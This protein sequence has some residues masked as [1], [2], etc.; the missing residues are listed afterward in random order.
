VIY[1]YALT[2]AVAR[3]P[4]CT[5]LADAPV[6]TVQAGGLSAIY[7]AHQTIDC[8][9]LPETLW[10]HDAV[11]ESAMRSGPTLPVRFGTTFEDAAPVLGVLRRQSSA[12]RDQLERVRG[13]VELAVRVAVPPPEAASSPDGRAYLE[14]RLASHRRREAVAQRTLEPLSRLAV[15][16]RERHAGA[17]GVLAASFLVRAGDVESFVDEVRSLQRGGERSLSC[18]GP[19][20]PYSFV[21][22]EV[23]T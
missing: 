18:T 2:D 5:G 11:V 20:A 1:L 10:R 12:L 7:S 13:C 15:S 23:P 16:T 22:R 14:S 21:D 4:D 3:I 8:R 19:W 6:Q 9:A 17:P